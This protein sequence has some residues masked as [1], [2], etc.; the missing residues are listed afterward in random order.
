MQPDLNR[1]TT[2]SV[3]VNTKQKS[4]HRR[5]MT[6]HL[7]TFII[8]MAFTAFAFMAVWLEIVENT[9][10]LGMFILLLAV[11]QVFFQLY[12]WMHLNQKGH[13]M[14]NAFILYGIFVAIITVAGLM[15]LI[16]W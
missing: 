6:H 11:I 15:L 1:G 13:D 14:P 3:S 5:E 8:S 9:T 12:I 4:H 16:W 2:A 7:W 10:L